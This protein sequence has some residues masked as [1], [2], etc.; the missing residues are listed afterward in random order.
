M[1]KTRLVTLML[2]LSLF[3]MTSALKGGKEEFWQPY[4][5]K[6]TEHFKYSVKITEDGEVKE[7]FYVLDLKKE[8]EDQFKVHIK[9]K[10]GKSS[11]ESTITAD[12][13]NI[14]GNLIPQLMFNPAAA[15]M[16]LTLFAP[17]WGVYFVGHDW[18]VGSG[19]S[20]TDEEGKSVS[21][22]IEAECH[23]AGQK[24]KKGVW[25][26]NDKVKAEFCIATKVA[27]PLALLFND[28]EGQSYEVVL[29]EYEE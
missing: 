5:F 14:Y 9:A 13:E 28:E 21:F 7:G 12:K 20:F 11:F 19:W 29:E 8:G 3:G 18:K 10:L 24:G 27:L 25:K 6:G 17:W 1:R 2:L 22:K 16:M 23:Y 15:P 26:E 4:K